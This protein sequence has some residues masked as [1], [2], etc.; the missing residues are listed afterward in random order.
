MLSNNFVFLNTVWNVYRYRSTLAGAIEPHM[1]VQLGVS[2]K[3]LIYSPQT[4]SI[5]TEPGTKV[6]ERIVYVDRFAHVWN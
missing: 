3:W 6:L 2:N 4:D 5:P 1:F